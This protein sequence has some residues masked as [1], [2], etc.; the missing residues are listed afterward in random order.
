MWGRVEWGLPEAASQL[1]AEKA[2][3]SVFALVGTCELALSVLAGLSVQ[4]CLGLGH[5]Q[6]TVTFIGIRFSFCAEAVTYT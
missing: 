1:V 4:D 3:E 2:L 6:Q 5:L